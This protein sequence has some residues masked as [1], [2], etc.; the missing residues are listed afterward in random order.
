MDWDKVWTKTHN[1]G[2]VFD[3]AIFSLN[4]IHLK[5]LKLNKTKQ[6]SQEDKKKPPADSYLWPWYSVVP[7]LGSYT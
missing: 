4:N 7:G 2:W 1:R 6:N 3:F 5:Y